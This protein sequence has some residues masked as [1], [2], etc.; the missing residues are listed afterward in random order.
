MR[1]RVRQRERRRPFLAL[2]RPKPAHLTSSLVMSR[3][4]QQLTEAAVF[5]FGNL[6]QTIARTVQDKVG[7]F[8]KVQHCTPRKLESPEAIFEDL[9]TS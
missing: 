9:C 5:A 2:G 8:K 1:L 6:C 3:I 4:N 7:I